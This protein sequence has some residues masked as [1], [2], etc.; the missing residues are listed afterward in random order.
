[1]FPYVE[2]PVLRLGGF[3][4]SAFQALVFVAVVAG[5]EITTRRAQRLGWNADD[6]LAVVLWAVFAG[7]V[8]SH[9]FDT[10][11]YEREALR[12]NPLVLLEFWGTMSSYGGLLGG[13]AGGVAAMRRRRFSLAKGLAFFDILAFAFPFAWLFGRLGC[14]LAHD[15]I[16][17]ASQSFLAVRFPGGP[18]FDLGLLE[19]FWTIAIC[20]VFLAADRR[21]RPAGFFVAAFLVL[22]APV[23]FA[24]DM[25]RIGDERYFGW[26]PAQYASLAA[27]AAGL[28][29]L[30]RLRPLAKSA[31][32]TNT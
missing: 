32:G 14:S 5:Y 4:I 20:A 7:F 26:T 11:L 9:L 3:S 16:G 22:Y 12:R 21:P 2:E 30:N 25:L 27:V 17:V 18:R 24:L 6:V 28:L 8:G 13:I 15:H 19:L 1:M 31:P 10:L 23:R 29:L